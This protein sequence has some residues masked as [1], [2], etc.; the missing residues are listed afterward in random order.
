M[1]DRQILSANSRQGDLIFFSQILSVRNE[2]RH[3][4]LFQT[5]LK[6]P[7]YFRIC[8]IH[9]IGVLDT[10]VIHHWLAINVGFFGD[11]ARFSRSDAGLGAC[12][13]E[14]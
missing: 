8:A 14:P 7:L 13:C 10:I 12:P 11:C 3:E 6:P 2:G 4:A 5:W 1:R 9:P